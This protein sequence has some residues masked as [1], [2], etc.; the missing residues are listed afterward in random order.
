M[1]GERRKKFWTE[2]EDG[3]L[4]RLYPIT[5]TEH[6][7]I[8]F[9][10]NPRSL[11]KRANL[12]GLKKSAAWLKSEEAC[13]L[14]RCPEAGAPGRFKAGHVPLNKGLRRPGYGPGRMKETQFKKGNRPPKWEPIGSTRFSKEGYLQ[15]KVAD[16]GY[17]PQDWV[18]E[19]VLLWVK[20]QKKNEAARQRAGKGGGANGAALP[21]RHDGVPRGYAIVFRDGDKSHIALDNLECVSRAELM[22]RN[23]VH[24][25]PKDLQVVIQLAGALKR[26]VRTL[27]EKYAR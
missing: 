10:R 25:L 8:Y 3:V 20:A 7:A 17:P 18:A 6:L 27:N 24:N 19:H 21:L 2:Y 11:Y 1:E 26:K 14:K 12:L 23:S 15:R 9:E 13:Y 5:K 16:T 4:R 22:R